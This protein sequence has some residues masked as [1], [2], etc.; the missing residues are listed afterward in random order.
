MINMEE[1]TAE[2]LSDKITVESIT[3]QIEKGWTN[4]FFILENIVGLDASRSLPEWDK[5][6]LAARVHKIVMENDRLKKM[7]FE[8]DIKR[9]KKD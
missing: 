4:P 3:E 7:Y 1:M 6:I 9:R 2:K 8:I 5:K